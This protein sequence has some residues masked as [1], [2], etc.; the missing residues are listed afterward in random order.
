VN[1]R[2][3]AAVA[4]LLV[5]GAIVWWLVAAGEPTPDEVG[6]A[7]APTDALSSQPV[8][9]PRTGTKGTAPAP[10]APA[11]ADGAVAADG[12]N[13]DAPAEEGPR[14]ANAR[15]DDND[16]NDDDDDAASGTPPPARH[17]DGAPVGTL[18]KEAIQAAIKAVVPRVKQCFEQGLKKEPDLAGRVVVQFEI[19]ADEEGRGVVNKGEVPESETVSPFFDACVLKEVAGAEFP[20]PEGGGKVVVRYPFQFDPGGGFGGQPAEGE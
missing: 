3:A 9:T 4:V 15:D 11:G 17:A 1:A 13:D 5:A 6:L 14:E 19:E 8:T 12:A 18:S 16:D 7:P 2:A 20:A 10:A